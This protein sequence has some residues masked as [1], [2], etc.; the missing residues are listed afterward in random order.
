ML[1]AKETVREGMGGRGVRKSVV[2]WGSHTTYAW[3][4][5]GS[6]CG[7]DRQSLLRSTSNIITSIFTDIVVCM[8]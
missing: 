8:K 1:L 7:A 2:R 3:A 5:S 6:I 4:G